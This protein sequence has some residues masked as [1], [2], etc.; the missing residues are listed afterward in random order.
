MVVEFIL[1]TSLP[2]INPFLSYHE[3]KSSSSSSNHSKSI[4]I[5]AFQEWSRIITDFEVLSVLG[6]GTYSVVYK[7]KSRL[8]GITYAIKKL[9]KAVTNEREKQL[10][11]RESCAVSCLHIPLNSSSHSTCYDSIIQNLIRQYEFCL[12]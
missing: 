9:K 6:E 3:Q 11:A 5:T 12:P 4:W 2:I 8:D 10:I 7:A 1:R